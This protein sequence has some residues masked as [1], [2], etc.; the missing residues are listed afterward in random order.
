M[1]MNTE[2]KVQ[3]T[4]I[5][6]NLLAPPAEYFNDGTDNNA[7]IAEHIDILLLSI[8]IAYTP[9]TISAFWQLSR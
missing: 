9:H 8:P 3:I 6:S 2:H 1:S 4:L 7:S 5:Q